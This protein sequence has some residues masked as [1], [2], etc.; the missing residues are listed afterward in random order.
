MSLKWIEKYLI[1]INKKFLQQS[2]IYFYGNDKL[3]YSNNGV[4]YGIN[5]NDGKQFFSYHL[6]EERKLLGFRITKDRLIIIY[7][8]EKDYFKYGR[9]L[10][11]KVSILDLHSEKE[12]FKLNIPST[13]IILVSF[14]TNNIIVENYLFDSNNNYKEIIISDQKISKELI[15]SINLNDTILMDNHNIY[16]INKN[17]LYKNSF[18]V[19]IN[20]KKFHLTKKNKFNDSFIKLKYKIIRNNR[21]KKETFLI[22]DTPLPRNIIYNDNEFILYTDNIIYNSS[23]IIKIG[24][25]KEIIFNDVNYFN[26]IINDVSPNGK[27]LVI[28]NLER[29][30]FE[31]YHFENEVYQS[32][33][34][35]FGRLAMS[36]FMHSGETIYVYDDY[37][38]REKYNKNLLFTIFTFIPTF[39]E[40]HNEEEFYL[41]GYKISDLNQLI[42]EISTNSEITNKNLC[43]YLS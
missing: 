32:K 19:S 1:N 3:Y 30:R 16:D 2:D 24:K 10:K 33:I 31:I 26:S 23:E 43:K 42:K 4:I 6:D 22:Y 7:Y 14:L 38:D 9:K 12:L 37:D 39:L 40:E 41:K 35:D 5:L 25:N 15:D 20:N 18:Y 34:E 13:F 36:E 27:W 29:N 28:V 11:F 8:Y 21:I 17:T